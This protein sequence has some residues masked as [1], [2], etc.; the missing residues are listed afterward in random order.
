MSDLVGNSEY[1]FSHDHDDAAH[2]VLFLSCSVPAEVSPVTPKEAEAGS[3]VVLEC[4]VQ[5]NPMVSNMVSWRRDDFDMTRA[6]QGYDT[7]T[8]TLTIEAVTKLDSGWFTCI[9]DNGIGTP[10][11]ARVE[12]KVE[13]KFTA[14]KKALSKVLLTVKFLN[15]LDARKLRCNLPK[16]Q[17]RRSNFRVLPQKDAN[18]IT[19]SEDPD[20]TAPLGAGN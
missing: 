13:C 3:T 20:Q 19:N 12:L 14:V 17:T 7:G 4:S 18:G 11:E 5:G 8:G 1:R 15:V 10:T 16:I 6:L 2:F 9:G